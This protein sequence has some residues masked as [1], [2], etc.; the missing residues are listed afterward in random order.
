[1]SQPP[2]PAREDRETHSVNLV[3]EDG[4]NLLECIGI[5]ECGEIA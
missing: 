1:M 3:S 2:R 4:L 5:L